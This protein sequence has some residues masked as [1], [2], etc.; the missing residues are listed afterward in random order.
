MAL[1]LIPALEIKVLP[2]MQL[3]FKVEITTFVVDLPLPL[4]VPALN[5]VLCNVPVSHYDHTPCQG[6]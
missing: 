5:L 6:V 2:R 3:T 4:S 1:V